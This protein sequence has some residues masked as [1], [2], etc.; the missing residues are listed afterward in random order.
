M[1]QADPTAPGH[2]RCHGGTRR[3]RAAAVGARRLPPGLLEPVDAHR[4]LRGPYTAAGTVARA[5]VPAVLAADPE[6]VR[7]HDIELL[8]VAPELADLV[9]NSRETLTSMALPAE[10]TRFYA[11]LRTRRI[12]G[13]LVEFVRDALPA[14]GH[15]GPRCLLVE[16]VEHAEAT[17]REFLAALLRRVDADVLTVV[18]CGAHAPDPGGVL[19]SV[20]EHRTTEVAVRPDDSA[21]AADAGDGGDEEQARRWVEADGLLDGPDGEAA[22]RAYRSLP[23][24]DRAAL[25]DRRAARLR[26]AEEFSLA[27]GALP[28]HLERGS[29]PVAEAVPAL[30]TASDHCLVNG[31]YDAVVDYGR[32]GQRL[33]DGRQDSGRWWRFGVQLGLALSILGRTKEAEAVYDEARLLSTDPAVHMACAYSTAMLYT[34]HNDPADR[35]EKKAKA[36]LNGAIATA[37]LLQDRVERAFQSAF[38][39]NGRALVEVNLGDPQ[40]ALRLVTECIEDLDERLTPDEHRLHRSVLKN[41]RARVYAGLGR[42]DD[43]LA[44]YAVVIEQDPNHAEHYLERGNLFRRLGRTGEA[45]ADY[46]RALSLSPPF[47]E[48]YYNRGDL[49]LNEGDV[50]GA[51][52]DFGYVIE[53]DP[54]FVDAYIN[55]CAIHLEAG[56]PAAALADAR[57]GLRV[58]PDNA[59]LHA[60]VGQALTE[61]GEPGEAEAAYDRAVAADPDLVSALSGRAG[62]RYEAGRLQDALADLCRAV[63]LAP[64]DPALRYNR[65]FLHQEAGHRQEALDDLELAAVLD[66]EDAE[67]A[68]ALAAL[69]GRPD[70]A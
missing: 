48:I 39:R 51:L 50:D 29:D 46:S 44:D 21:P 56:D 24:A 64:K 58:D 37:S 27:L 60:A 67:T 57:A 7:R 61:S 70:G 25:H 9:P 63:E 18:L 20:L 49:R 40:E 31:F 41:N 45:L 38:Y 65:A 43:A 17:D 6:L 10:R 32:R 53:Q 23:D 47:P 26:E 28:Y 4:R 5:L 8:S 36:L 54:E 66:P 59:H 3:S 34:R 15:D 35:D 19:A 52:A 12:A 69:R 62:V 55:R 1:Q 30:W 2:L 16:N 33:V 14:L 13:G 22:R 11:R 42:L 68:E